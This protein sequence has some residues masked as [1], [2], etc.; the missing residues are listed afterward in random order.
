M[1]IKEQKSPT[2]EDG[3]TLEFPKRTYDRDDLDIPAFLRRSR[4]VLTPRCGDIGTLELQ[5]IMLAAL[6]CEPLHLRKRPHRGGPRRSPRGNLT[7]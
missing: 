4:Q 5:Q 2:T 7:L 6:R 3:K 1:P